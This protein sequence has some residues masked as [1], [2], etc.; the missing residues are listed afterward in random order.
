MDEKTRSAKDLP[1]PVIHN[2]FYSDALEIH[3]MDESLPLLSCYW[4]TGDHIP[5]KVMGKF[6]IILEQNQQ[7][8]RNMDESFPLLS[9]YWVTARRLIPNK[10]IRKFEIILEQNQQSRWQMDESLPLLSSYW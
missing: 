10:V 1:M 7:S 6:E 5:N 2:E 4:V 8:R 9:C 3:H